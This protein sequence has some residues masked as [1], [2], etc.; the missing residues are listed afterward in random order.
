MRVTGKIFPSVMCS[1]SNQMRIYYDCATFKHPYG[2]DRRVSLRVGSSVMKITPLLTHWT[3]S[4]HQC[5]LQSRFLR[6]VALHPSQPRKWKLAEGM[7]A[8]RPSC[9]SPCRTATG[10]SEATTAKQTPLPRSSPRSRIWEIIKKATKQWATC[11]R[12]KSPSL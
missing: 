1:T 4:A 11:S 9:A 2:K 8:T 12:A 5:E 10:K 6:Q 3:T 7:A